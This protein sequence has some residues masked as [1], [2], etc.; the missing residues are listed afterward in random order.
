MTATTTGSVLDILE[1]SAGDA[2]RKILLRGGYVLSVDPTIGDLTCDVL[3]E[4]GI[5]AAVGH[6]VHVGDGVIDIDVSES[7]VMPGMVDAHLHAWEGQLRSLAPDLSLEDYTTLVH[8]RLGPSYRAED[9]L[10]GNFI[11]ALQCLN[12]GVTCFIDSSHNSRSVDHSNAAVEGLRRAGIRAVHASGAPIA[13][14]WDEQWPDDLHRLRKEYFSSNDQLLTLRMFAPMPH[15][16]TWAFAQRNGLR[17]STEMGGWFWSASL[18]ELLGEHHTFNHCAGLSSEAWAAIR[19]AGVTVNVCPRS[20]TTFG[21][22]P[23]TLPIDQAIHYGLRPGLSMDNEICYGIDMF[24]EMRMLLHLQ[25]AAALRRR[26]EQQDGPA[27]ID[28]RDVLEFATLGGAANA[29]LDHRIGSL[30]PG[31]AADVIVLR[32]DAVNTMPLASVIGGAVSFV[33]AS[34]VDAVFVAGQV[35][36]WNG[37]LV[38]HDLAAV[39]RMAEASREHVLEASAVQLERFLPVSHAR[40]ATG[41]R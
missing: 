36:K 35:R 37:V 28:V 4:G 29:G 30:K 16:D 8:H 27:P 24:S 21:I 41:H 17:V 38:G 14:R 19:D 12:A 11:T 9:M 32:T 6:D 31:K 15:P 1:R 40:T 13:G 10:I 25:R 7:I 2:G 18:V 20:D 3:I 26:A 5:I 23:S 33:N 22:G 39:R 34:N